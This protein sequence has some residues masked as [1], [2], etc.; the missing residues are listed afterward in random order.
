MGYRLTKSAEEDLLGIFLHGMDRY[1][2]DQARHYHRDFERCF[3]FLSDYP[4]ASPART[5]LNPQVCIHPCNQHL[6]IYLIDDDE[7]I[8]IVRVRHSS[9]DWVTYPLG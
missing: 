1:G 2:L 9:E 3:R 6:V 4:Q 8:L 5:E 7:E